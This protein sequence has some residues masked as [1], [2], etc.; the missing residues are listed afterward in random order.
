MD[1]TVAVES[2][3]VAETPAPARTRLVSLD[4]FR[5]LTIAGM[6]LVNN[7]GD[8]GHVYGPLEHAEWHGWTPTDLIFPFFLFIIGVAMPY[9]FARRVE[10]GDTKGRLALHVL[11]RSVVLIA[12]GM[13]LSGLPDFDFSKKLI[14]DVLQRIGVVYLFAGL[15]F[16]VADAAVQAVV[17]LVCLV[18]YWVLMVTIPVPGFGAGVLAPEGNVWQYVDNLIIAGWHQHAEGVLS[19]IPS[20]STVLLGTLTG[21]WL[22]SER[23]PWE[24]L[25]GM[26]A[27]GNLALALGLIMAASFPINKLLW[28][29]SYVVFTAGFALVVLAF[30]YWLVDMKQWKRAPRPFVIFGMNAIAAFFL[31]SLTSRL[32]GMAGVK[33]PVDR[34]LFA[35]W[36]PPFDA[37][38]AWAICYVLLWLGVMGI[39]YRK[40]LFLKI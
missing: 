8:W 36:L 21:F 28:S 33:G 13:F 39:L 34:T 19:I 40:H 23:Q 38:L 3:H 11:Y 31:S 1:Q 25:V 32:M 14:L 37:S 20:I 26:F 7:P 12:L 22:R 9:S 10:R 24:K 4:V 15:V 30:C 29:P 18:L 5:G 16:I 35:S 6:I 27:A 2:P 17:A